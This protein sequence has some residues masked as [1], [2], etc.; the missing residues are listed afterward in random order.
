MSENVGAV[1]AATLG[2]D[3]DAVAVGVDSGAGLAVGVDSDAGLAVGGGGADWP[4][5]PQAP[6]ANTTRR[7]RAARA[8]G[9]RMAISPLR[10]SWEEIV[11]RPNPLPA[12]DQRPTP[13]PTTFLD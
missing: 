4:P 1:D 13:S 12:V 9:V 3:W 2:V 5:P 7:A 10:R 6:T 11:A 8:R